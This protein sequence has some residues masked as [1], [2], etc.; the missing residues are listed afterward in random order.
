MHNTVEFSNSIQD[1]RIN[2]QGFLNSADRAN[3]GVNFGN[4]WEK[5]ILDLGSGDT[6][7]SEASFHW[8]RENWKRAHWERGRPARIA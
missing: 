7:Q 8:E 1:E 4:S 6:L 5:V 3:R 2:E